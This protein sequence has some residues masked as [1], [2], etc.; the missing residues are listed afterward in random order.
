MSHVKLVESPPNMLADYKG[1]TIDFICEDCEILKRI[2]PAALMEEHGNLSMPSLP[3]LVAKSL[4]CK[5]TESTVYNRC[6]MHY[7]FSPDEWAKRMGYVN[8]QEHRKDALLF[9]DLR[10]WHRLYAHCSCGRKSEIDAVKLKK[11]LGE[12]APVSGA[13]SVLRCRKCGLKGLANIVVTSLARG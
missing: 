3:A 10:E 7:H 4:G 1:E 12:D 11:A 2:K 6:K 13:S 8:P 9:S 5:R